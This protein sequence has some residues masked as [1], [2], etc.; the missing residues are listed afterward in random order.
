M[1]ISELSAQTGVSVPTIKYYLREGLLPE[2]E[3]SAPT[4]AA[5]GEKHVERLRVIRALLDAG[6]SIAETRRVLGALDDPPED[7]HLLLGA[8]HSAITPAVGDPL[9]LAEAERLVAGLGWKPGM[10]DASVL[11]AVARALQGLEQA[12]F[13]VPDAVMAEYLASMRRIADVEIAG[14]PE[15]SAEAAVRYVVLGS[16]LVEPLLLALR[17]VAE[18]VSSGERFD[19]PV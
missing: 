1:R 7:P 16:V 13:E 4:Q 19:Q 14:V 11:N 17:R 8:A 3:R 15:E 12:G 5:Y 10:C 18:Q 9:D 6:V 2:G